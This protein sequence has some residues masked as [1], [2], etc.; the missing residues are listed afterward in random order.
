VPWSEESLCRAMALPGS[1]APAV[2]RCWRAVPRFA[3]PRGR[4]R[5]CVTLDSCGP[6]GAGAG[7][8]WPS[9]ELEETGR[10]KGASPGRTAREI[11]GRP[12]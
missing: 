8:R 4:L 5:R 6:A 7:K 11:A 2:G 12:L 1:S 10:G 9:V 3:V